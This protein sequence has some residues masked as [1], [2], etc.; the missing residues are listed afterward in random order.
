MELTLGAVGTTHPD[1]MRATANHAAVL[2]KQG[3]FARATAAERGILD[4]RKEILGPEHLDSIRAMVNLAASLYWQGPSVEAEAL[5][6]RAVELRRWHLGAT[7]PNTT[8]AESG[9][10]MV[11]QA[12]R[13]QEAANT[14]S[15]DEELQ[16]RSNENERTSSE[17]ALATTLC[18]GRG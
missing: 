6:Q 2:N 4:I 1:T 18:G 12:L 10:D 3:R 8:M 7:H 14:G 16:K 11:Q 15:D 13:A 17:T 9:L 5:M